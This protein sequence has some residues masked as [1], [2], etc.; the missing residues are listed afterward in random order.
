MCAGHRRGCMKGGLD[1]WIPLGIIKCIE[2]S[3]FLASHIHHLYFWGE[4]QTHPN[5]PSIFHNPCDP[6]SS[7]ALPSSLTQYTGFS[8]C[9]IPA[10]PLSGLRSC[11]HTT[12]TVWNFLFCLLPHPTLSL[13]HPFK[14]VFLWKE[15]LNSQREPDLFTTLIVSYI[16]PQ[17]DQLSNRHILL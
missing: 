16:F 6:I 10:H 12:H 7:P 15:I 14:Y 2:Q 11:K 5:R 4:F 13:T 8:F 1:C 3:Y 9:L 17:M